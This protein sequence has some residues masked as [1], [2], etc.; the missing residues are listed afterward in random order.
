MTFQ[1]DPTSALATELVVDPAPTKGPLGKAK[2]KRKRAVQRALDTA[3]SADP[4]EE[5]RV[6]VGRYTRMTRHAVRIAQPTKP[7]KMADGTTRL[8]D[9]DADVADHLKG[10]AKVLAKYAKQLVPRMEVLLKQ[11]PIY[12]LFLKPAYGVGPIVAAYLIARI[13]IWKSTKMSNLKSFCGM[14]VIDGRLQRVQHAPKEQGGEGSPCAV[15]R[16]V[17]FQMFAAMARNSCKG[18]GGQPAT[19][20]KYLQVWHDYLHRMAHSERIQDDGRI[21]RLG[22]PEG[23]ANK[24]AKAAGFVR[25]TGWHKACDVF[26][27]DYY[28]IA[29]TLAGMPV[30]P[31]YYSAKLGYQHAS[32]K[33][34]VNEP[35]MLTIKEALELV[36]D[37][38]GRPCAAPPV[39]ALK[40]ITD[41][42]I[43]DEADALGLGLEELN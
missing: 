7:W 21:L 33:I 11:M 17:L 14:A 3:P 27:E 42:D 39:P 24:P 35:K 40:D 23:V 15:I 9:I 34:V 20:S 13:K 22:T 1:D 5:L 2:A 25:S 31:S 6:L 19:T 16:T 12:T 41:D 32:G 29:R 36:G 43:D 18:S 28:V 26:L 30:W 38:G 4:I 8:P 10:S 37:V